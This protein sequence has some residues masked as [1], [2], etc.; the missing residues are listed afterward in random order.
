MSIWIKTTPHPLNKTQ[1]ERKPFL[2][3]NIH[4]H[5]CSLPCNN[6]WCLI[7]FFYMNKWL[8]AKWSEGNPE[9][10]EVFTMHVRMRESALEMLLSD[11]CVRRAKLLHTNC[12]LC[13]PNHPT[14]SRSD[15]KN[16]SCHIC[17]SYMGMRTHYYHDFSYEKLK[18]FLTII[19]TLK[20]RYRGPH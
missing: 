7:F 18:L 16:V 15:P 6:I 12:F 8:C 19:S 3:F 20:I 17:L 10:T 14:F 2:P 1:H 13:S 11:K 4:V 9:R 5:W